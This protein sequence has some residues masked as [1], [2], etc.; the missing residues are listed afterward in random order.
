M[1]MDEK[2]RDAASFRVNSVEFFVLLEGKTDPAGE[3]RKLEVEMKYEKG[4]LKSVTGKLN[5][6][7][8]INNAPDQVVEKER[9]KKDDTE[10]KIRVLEERINDLRG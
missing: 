5:D 4:F 3:L 2:V 7:R 10:K 8:F 1:Q 9:K 6:E